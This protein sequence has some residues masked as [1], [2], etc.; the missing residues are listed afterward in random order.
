MEND[1]RKQIYNYHNVLETEDLLETWQKHDT[2]EWREETFEIIEQILLERLG[3]L[4]PRPVE[5]E[6]NQILNA[7]SQAGNLAQTLND[8]Y[9]ATQLTP[10]QAEVYISR[11]LIHEEMGQAA[12]ALADYREAIRLDPESM[13]AAEYIVNLEKEFKEEFENSPSKIH[14]D[15]ALEFALDH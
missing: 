5:E 7:N 8:C 9:L 10:D 13:E 3:Q 2:D 4:P 15:Q 12:E 1:L 6:V 11:G 14:L